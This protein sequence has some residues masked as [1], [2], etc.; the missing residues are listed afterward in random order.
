MNE[1]NRRSWLF[2]TING[3]KEVSFCQRCFSVLF[4]GFF[5]TPFRGA[6]LVTRQLKRVGGGGF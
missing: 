2:S 6:H 5:V 3:R 4:C 1:L